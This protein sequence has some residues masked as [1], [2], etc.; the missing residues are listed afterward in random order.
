MNKEKKVRTIIRF[1]VVVVCQGWVLM[2]CAQNESW[3]NVMEP[4]DLSPFGQPTGEWMVSGNVS[5]D[6]QDE[7][8][9]LSN[10]GAGVVHNGKGNTENLI[11]TRL[12][13]ITVDCHDIS[14]RLSQG[15]GQISQ[16]C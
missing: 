6:A 8:R 9:L 2:S 5:L 1:C 14:A 15:H 11:E 10:A 4:G 7:R 12:P 16:H 13:K 3:S